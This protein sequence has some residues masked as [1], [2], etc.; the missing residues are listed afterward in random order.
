LDLRSGFVACSPALPRYCCVP[1]L[2]NFGF[3]VVLR[4]D[5]LLLMPR[6]AFSPVC[7]AFCRCCR[8]PPLRVVVVVALLFCCCCCFRCCI[9][10]SDS[11]VMIVYCVVRCLRVFRVFYL[12]RLFA[13]WIPFSS[14]PGYISP[15]LNLRYF[16]VRFLLLLPVIWNACGYLYVLIL[17]AFLFTGRWICCCTGCYGCCWTILYAVACCCD[18]RSTFCVLR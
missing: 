10:C 17:V 1:L 14:A 8:L 7:R 6:C 2:P 13:V 5:C 16:V 3:L 12:P 9:T 4:C 11:N 15:Y 18:A